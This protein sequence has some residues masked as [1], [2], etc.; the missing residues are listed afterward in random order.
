MPE[1]MYTYSNHKITGENG[2]SAEI[3]PENHW[4]EIA[5][6]GSINVK[7]S[8]ENGVYVI[9]DNFLEAGYV[10]RN[11]SMEFKGNN[12]KIDP[13]GLKNLNSNTINFY[14]ISGDES[15]AFINVF[16][17]EVNIDL[18]EPEHL[19]PVMIYIAL[20]SKRLRIF[21]GKVHVKNWSAPMLS[22]SVS[23]FGGLITTVGLNVAKTEQLILIMLPI[24]ALTISLLYFI[25]RRGKL[26]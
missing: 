9:R 21:G 16:R 24:V 5:I 15:V 10:S 25:L 22:I 14:V 11:S 19:I 3:I 12:F 23:M 7:L 2:F 13:Q 4:K 8:L 6:E 26:F 20:L 1:E 18:D 17:K